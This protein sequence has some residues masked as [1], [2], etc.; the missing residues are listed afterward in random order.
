MK[1]SQI[2]NVLVVS[3]GNNSSRRPPILVRNKLDC[4]IISQFIDTEGRLILLN[5]NI[6]DTITTLVGSYAPN[7]KTIVKPSRIKVF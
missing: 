1:N 3:Y 2:I 5:T 7:S 6:K 4:E